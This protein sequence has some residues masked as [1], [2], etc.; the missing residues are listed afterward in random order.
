MVSK[1]RLWGPCSKI[2]MTLSIFELEAQNCTW[3]GRP[4][5]GHAKVAVAP[6]FQ[7]SLEKVI[8]KIVFSRVIKF[9][10]WPEKI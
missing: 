4:R 8:G 6:P 2:I 5:V 7:V 9:L 1:Y 3:Q 10:Y